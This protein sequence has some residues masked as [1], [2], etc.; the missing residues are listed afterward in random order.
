MG[1]LVGRPAVEGSPVGGS[2]GWDSL[3][4]ERSLVVERSPVVGGIPVVGDN[5]A[6]GNNL[7]TR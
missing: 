1:R 6:V 3:V 4:G 7:G 2:P 5:P